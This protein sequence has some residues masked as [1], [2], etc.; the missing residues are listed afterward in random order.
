MGKGVALEFKKRFPAMFSDYQKR[1]AGKVVHPG[2]PYLWEDDAAVVLNFPTKDHWKRDSKLEYIE[3][4]L[5]WLAESYQDLGIHTIAMPPLGCGN[6]GL[7]W[8]EVKL[9]MKQY[10]ADIPD[11]EVFVYEPV[12][13]DVITGTSDDKLKELP[14]SSIV[15]RSAASVM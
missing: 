15:P 10:L 14:N 7:N 3:A 5:K 9:L 8:H 4:G 6:G 1:C 2:A 11:L 12:L 13:A